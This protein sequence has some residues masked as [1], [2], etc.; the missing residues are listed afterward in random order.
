[1][2]KHSAQDGFTIIE[3]M[4]CIVVIAAI[5]LF[6]LTT[7]RSER[8]EKRDTQRKS[9][10]NA[11]YYQLESFHEANSY[12]PQTI[13]AKTLKG[14]DPESLLDSTGKTIDQAGSEYTYKPVGCA[15]N[16]CKSYE[17]GTELEKEAPLLKQ[18]L[19]R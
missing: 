2:K 4:V 5:S 3:L 16:K 17:I 13:T 11:T 9:D 18:S 10:I 1:M 19:I 8:A 6:A 15:E 12:Y 7:I 14:I